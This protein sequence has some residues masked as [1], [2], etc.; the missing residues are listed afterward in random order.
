MFSYKKLKE[1]NYTF[2]GTYKDH[3]EEIAE[4]LNIRLKSII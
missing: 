2:E 1:G 4:Y 3:M